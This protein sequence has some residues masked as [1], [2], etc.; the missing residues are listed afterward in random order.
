MKKA[1]LLAGVLLGLTGV[2]WILQGFNVLPGS[3]MTGQMIWAYI[4]IAVS[5]VGSVVIWIAV[6]GG[7]SEREGYP[8]RQ[9][10]RK[11][12]PGTYPPCPPGLEDGN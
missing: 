2:V 4:G 10:S 1:L 12:G 9:A 7:S 3:F 6:R 11:V 8:N 5:M